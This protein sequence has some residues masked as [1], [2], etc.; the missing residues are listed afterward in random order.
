VLWKA[1]AEFSQFVKTEVVK[2]TALAKEANI[3]PE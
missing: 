2:W 1:P 3:Q